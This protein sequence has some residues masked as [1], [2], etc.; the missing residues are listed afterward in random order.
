MQK[1]SPKKIVVKKKVAKS[2][3]EQAKKKKKD[4]SSFDSFIYR[5]LKQVHPDTGMGGDASVVCDNL[6]KIFIRKVMMQANN[7]LR[8]KNV[9]VITL[10]SRE[11]L[12]ALQ[13]VLPG[14]LRKHAHSEA[15]KAIT[16]YQSSLDDKERKTRSFRA[17]LQISVSRVEKYMKKY[18]MVKNK[19]GTSAIA[20]AAAAEYI[21]AE[22]LELSGNTSRDNKKVRIIPRH[23]TLAIGND[24]ELNELFKDTFIGGGVIPGF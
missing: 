7:L 16:K 19:S 20:M 18:S 5:I 24:E 22:V 6:L 17:G 23:I 4:F 10:K 8:H 15:T 1:S 14:E 3:D 11:I 21:M 13:L 2:D 9:E 12:Y